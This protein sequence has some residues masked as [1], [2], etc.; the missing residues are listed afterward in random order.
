M[1]VELKDGR[2]RTCRGQ[3]EI[4]HVDDAFMEVVCMD[5]N[6]SFHVEPHALGDSGL[7][8]FLADEGTTKVIRPGEKLDVVADNDLG[9][10]C[11]ASPAISQGQIFIRGEKHL[12]C[13]GKQK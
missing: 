5:C 7:V 8:Y 10:S 1:K 9:E 6:D 3:L 2:C 11:Y 4:V 13:I 12:F